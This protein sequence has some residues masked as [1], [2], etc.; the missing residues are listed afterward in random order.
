[1]SAAFALDYTGDPLPCDFPGCIL[2]AWHG[3][4]HKFPQPKLPLGKRAEDIRR[5]VICGA[6]FV[7]FNE[8][9]YLSI[10]TC[11]HDCLLINS[12]REA[13]ELPL[14]CKCPQ[15]SYPHELSAHVELRSES[16]NPNLKHRWPWSLCLSQRL[17]PSA[18]TRRAA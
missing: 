16:Y 17:E 13:C 7:V 10:R 12:I 2:D 11:S 4:D 14:L 18:E 8:L 6:G 5:C 3:G 1:V 15:R 9:D